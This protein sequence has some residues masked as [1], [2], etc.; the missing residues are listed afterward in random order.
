VWLANAVL[1]LL[2]DPLLASSGSIRV[3]AK[4]RAGAPLD[5][6]AIRSVEPTHAR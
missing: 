5:M 1:R 3:V 2:P 4:R 6:R